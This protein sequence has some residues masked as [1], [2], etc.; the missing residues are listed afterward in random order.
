MAGPEDGLSIIYLLKGWNRTVIYWK[1]G[2]CKQW[3]INCRNKKTVGKQKK[4]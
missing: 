2:G 3:I 1:G 4:S